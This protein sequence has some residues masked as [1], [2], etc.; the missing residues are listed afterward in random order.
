MLQNPYDFPPSAHPKDSLTPPSARPIDKYIKSLGRFSCVL[1]MLGIIAFYFIRV[2]I[3]SFNFLNFYIY[4]IFNLK[5][6]II[7][8]Y[9]WYSLY[10]YA[11][12]ACPFPVT[13]FMFPKKAGSQLP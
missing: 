5:F 8:A 4:F 9:G 13:S 11:V 2:N 1:N 6:V 10:A 3:K 12:A 7:M